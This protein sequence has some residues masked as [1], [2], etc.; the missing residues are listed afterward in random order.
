TNPMEKRTRVRARVIS[1]ALKDLIKESDNVIIMGHRTPDLDSLGAALGVLNIVQSNEI[2]GFI[3][4]DK[5]DKT[6]GVSRVIKEIK[7]E[8]SLWRYFIGPEESE[9][10]CTSRSLIV[11]VDTHRPSHVAHEKLLREANRFV[12]IDHH[13][14][15]E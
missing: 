2:D 7:K 5:E 6:V 12:V 3:L 1:H 4:F 13:R 14:R 10:I 8:D 11:I 15:G 9:A